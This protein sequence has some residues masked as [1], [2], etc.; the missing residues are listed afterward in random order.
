MGGKGSPISKLGNQTLTGMLIRHTLSL[1]SR[2]LRYSTLFRKEI[3]MT[4]SRLLLLGMMTALPV[5][6]QT[7]DPG[8]NVAPAPAEQVMFTPAQA[9]MD[10]DPMTPLDPL[11]GA[12]FMTCV[13]DFSTPTL[14]TSGATCQAAQTA[15]IPILSGAANDDCAPNPACNL[16]HAFKWV[17]GN[18]CVVRGVAGYGCVGGGGGGG[19]GGGCGGPCDP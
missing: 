8:A 10:G 15:L 16:G 12:L 2:R 1:L 4:V 7:N 6:A 17:G 9:A 18:P 3:W 14:E 5:S 19:G 11:L 13:G